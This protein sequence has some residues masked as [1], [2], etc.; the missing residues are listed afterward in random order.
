MLAGRE[1]LLLPGVAALMV[2][3]GVLAAW[4]PARRALGVQPTEALRAE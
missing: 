1:T 3:V 4:G 2:L